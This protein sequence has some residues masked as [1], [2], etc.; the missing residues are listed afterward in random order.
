MVILYELKDL[1][2]HTKA[3]II[4]QPPEVEDIT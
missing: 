1:I 4:G 3:R 2:L